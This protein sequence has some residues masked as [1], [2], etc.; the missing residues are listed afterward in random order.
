[1]I[2]AV[3]LDVPKIVLIWKQIFMLD[4]SKVSKGT[5][6]GIES[7]QKW[8]SCN[9]NIL[10]EIFVYSF[11]KKVDNNLWERFENTRLIN[12][13]WFSAM[14]RVY[15]RFL[16]NTWATCWKLLFWFEFNTK[17]LCLEGCTRSRY[18]VCIIFLHWCSFTNMYH[19]GWI[20][21]G[22]WRGHLKVERWKLYYICFEFF[23]AK[24][25]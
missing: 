16:V 4:K 13:N 19:S 8:E 14:C 10:N 12:A 20:L 22:Q 6:N 9:D 5:Y 7:G 1:M 3:S 25:Y 21:F 23:F 17:P 11:S 15:M 18:C 24:E 2:Y